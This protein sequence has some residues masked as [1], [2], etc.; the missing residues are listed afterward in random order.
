MSG[1]EKKF[2]A[3]FKNRSKALVT[4]ITAGD[5][6][7]ETTKRLILLL[8]EK[9]AD[10]IE[11]GVPFSD[12]LA[13]GTT[14]Q[15]ASQRALNKGIN[16]RTILQAVEEIRTKSSLPL[17]LMSYYNP[18]MS[19]GIENFV[20]QAREV[21]VDGV[22]IPDLPPEEATALLKVSR[23][24]NFDLIFLVAPTSTA[25][26]VRLV[27]RYSTGFIYCVSVTGVTGA[28]EGIFKGLS[29]FVN[30]VRACT[31]K[32]L[33]VGFGISTPEQARHVAQVADGVIVG[34]ALVNIIEKYQDAPALMEEIGTF[35]REMKNSMV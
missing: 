22:I 7:I 1:I 34:S 10:I 20:A 29:D 3:L 18:I 14:I 13:D 25:E 16:L 2:K 5:P 4:Y 11:L 32:P 28:R 17:A 27:G 9:G 12:P 15:R 23:A 33:A 19:Y 26:R 30:R 21:G 31:D 24:K 8:E 35:V 6:D